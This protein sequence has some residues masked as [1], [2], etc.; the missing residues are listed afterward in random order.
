MFSQLPAILTSL[1]VFLHAVFGCFCCCEHDEFEADVESSAVVVESRCNDHANHHHDE[2]H[3]HQAHSEN[4][5]MPHHH[6][7]CCAACEGFL[8]WKTVDS[9]VDLSMIVAGWISQNDSVC[10]ISEPNSNR[11]FT[12]S[13]PESPHVPLYAHIAVWKI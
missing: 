13:S 4:Q 5:E 12:F 6:D 9:E 2:N 8:W 1:A 11:T 3:E 10:C 7:H